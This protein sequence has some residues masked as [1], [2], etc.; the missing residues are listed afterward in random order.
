MKKNINNITKKEEFIELEIKKLRE[1]KD[2]IILDEKVQNEIIWNLLKISAEKKDLSKREITTEQ[3]VI[4]VWFFIIIGFLIINVFLSFIK[5]PLLIYSIF[6]I[7][8]LVTLFLIFINFRKTRIDEVFNIINNWD[9]LPNDNRSDFVD[10]VKNEID[11]SYTSFLWTIARQK[12]YK[13]GIYI[14]LLFFVFSL[15]MMIFLMLQTPLNI[16]EELPR[17]GEISKKDFLFLYVSK[18]KDNYK[19]LTINTCVFTF[20]MFLN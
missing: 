3:I 9:D 8:I 19:N 7:I 15:S 6:F 20:L 4:Y 2:F 5:I 12:I 16:N 10:V 13:Y 17:L 18:L 1:S 11:I 14:I